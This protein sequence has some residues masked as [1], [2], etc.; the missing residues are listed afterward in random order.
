MGSYG[1]S[2]IPSDGLSTVIFAN[3]QLLLPFKSVL[4]YAKKQ[5]R[6]AI[7][8]WVEEDRGWFWHAGDYPTGW[9]KRVNVTNIS[10][11]T[12]KSSTQPK[13]AKKSDDSFEAW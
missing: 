8:E 6:S 13:S 7:F 5:S 12:K 1:F 4:V 2:L 9:E 10:V 11:P 3:P